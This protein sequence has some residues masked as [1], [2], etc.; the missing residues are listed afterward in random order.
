MRIAIDATE[1]ISTPTGVGRYL[2]QL[3]AAW[4][5]LP[6]ARPHEFILCSPAP[7]DA[8]G[9][10]LRV[11]HA[12][13]PG[14]G[15]RWQQVTL[16]RLLRTVRPDVLFAPAY[17]GP[18]LTS[19]PTVVSVHDVSFFAHPEWFGWREGLRL[20]LGTWLSARKA[21]RVL[22]FS[23]FS[24]REIVRRLGVP[25][26]KVDVTYHGVTS[27]AGAT[28]AP[29]TPP[30][31][32]S[33][34]PLVL[35]VGSLFTRRHV[36]ELIAGF[37]RLAARHPAARLEIVGHN[38]TRPYVDLHALAAATAGGSRIGIHSWVPDDR[39]ASFY[40]RATAFVF[41]S[42]YEGFAMTPAE[43]LA[44]G[45]PAV[46]LDTEVTREIYGP[47]ALYVARPDPELIDAA[48]ERA[49]FDPCERGQRLGAAPAVLAR[50]SW[51]ACAERTLQVL[52]SSAA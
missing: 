30:D 48:L 2:A 38:R 31:T 14:R 20:R 44:A 3:L 6:D 23:E 11:T 32:P 33:G 36:P 45:V 4:G 35:Y 37:S 15:T 27:F 22:T 8:P 41:L 17:T 25:V 28:S 42:D 29:R 49:L 10:A 12:V 39:L 7:V 1:L 40:R 47:A 16:P 21:V 13:A 51:R 5:E 9:G 34:E 46:V 52:V 18:L 50:Y 26:D 43:A 19:I 24:R